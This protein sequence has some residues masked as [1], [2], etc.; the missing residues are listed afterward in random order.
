MSV[1]VGLL[2][3]PGQP[4][5]FVPSFSEPH[6]KVD[7]VEA[8]EVFFTPEHVLLQWNVGFLKWD[9]FLLKLKRLIKFFFTLWLCFACECLEKDSL[10]YSPDFPERGGMDE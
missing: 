4:K 9:T 10:G 1:V 7:S 8:G 5:G 2:Q 6:R 3:H